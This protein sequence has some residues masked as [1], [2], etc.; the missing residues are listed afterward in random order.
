MLNFVKET[1]MCIHVCGYR[2]HHI[3]SDIVNTWWRDNASHVIVITLVRSIRNLS[4]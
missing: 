1:W 3:Y 4:K 2:S